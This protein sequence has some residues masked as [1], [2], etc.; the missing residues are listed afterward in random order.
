MGPP[1]FGFSIIWEWLRRA[2][3][4]NRQEVQMSYNL[5]VKREIGYLHVQVQGI[6][7]AEV[8]KTMTAEVLKLCLDGRYSRVLLDIRAMTGNLD[9]IDSYEFGSSYLPSLDAA[10]QIRAAVID[11]AENRNRFEMVMHNARI[12]GFDIRIVSSADEAKR[13]LGVGKGLAGG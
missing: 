12:K 1:G 5:M 4:G 6:R 2:L 13:W 9:P 7:T 3:A 11:L 10:G 8:L